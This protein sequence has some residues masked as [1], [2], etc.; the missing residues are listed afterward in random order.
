MGVGCLHDHG[1][2][3]SKA[4]RAVAKGQGSLISAGKFRFH[5][6]IRN[7]VSS[8]TCSILRISMLRTFMKTVTY[9]T[10]YEILYSLTST[11]LY[12]LYTVMYEYL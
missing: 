6:A 5:A 10:L 7:F 2:G 3:M 11:V 12:V 1:E 9:G 8:F 4:R